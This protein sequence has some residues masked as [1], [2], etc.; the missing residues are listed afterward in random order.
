MRSWRARRHGRAGH[1]AAVNRQRRAVTAMRA[2]AGVAM[3]ACVVSA[4]SGGMPAVERGGHAN[5]AELASRIRPERRRWREVS[6][7]RV[8]RGWPMH[9]RARRLAA[10][11]SSAAR[12]CRRQSPAAGRVRRSGPVGHRW[13]QASREALYGRRWRRGGMGQGEAASWWHGDRMAGQ[14][15]RGGRQLGPAMRHRY[16]SATEPERRGYWTPRRRCIGGMLNANSSNPS[17]REKGR[18]GWRRSWEAL[19]VPTGWLARR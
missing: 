19:R 12:D 3:L 16:N 5:G 14:P 17:N 13:P 15:A 7:G 2:P 11:P 8:R 1:V 10:W 6:A 18:A 9:G 4:I